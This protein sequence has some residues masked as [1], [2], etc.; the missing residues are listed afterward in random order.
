ME[1]GCCSKA[2]ASRAVQ[3]QVRFLPTCC[4]TLRPVFSGG[5]A[6]LSSEISETVEKSQDRRELFLSLSHAPVQATTLRAWRRLTMD[7]EG[8][9]S[10]RQRP[11][12]AG[13][14]SR[15][16]AQPDNAF[17]DGCSGQQQRPTPVRPSTQR[18]ARSV[19]RASV[20]AVRRM[21]GH[22][23]DE[24]ALG[25]ARSE[26]EA[27]RRKLRDTDL[28]KSQAQVPSYNAYCN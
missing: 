20:E 27:L 22:G 5:F 4:P 16:R 12:T 8:S 7:A 25:K 19:P 28:A 10:R 9:L 3:Y 1:R 26:V 18:T 14:P 13:Y 21:S 15:Q 11:T 6:A 17:E 2:G 23:P 24:E